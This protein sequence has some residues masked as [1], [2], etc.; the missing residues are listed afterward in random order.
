MGRTDGTMGTEEPTA[1][2]A[3]WL[4]LQWTQAVF[5]MA[6]TGGPGSRHGRP[7]EGRPSVPEAPASVDSVLP[8]WKPASVSD[9]RQCW[10][11]PM[12]ADTMPSGGLLAAVPG[13]PILLAKSGQIPQ[14]SSSP[15][16][17]T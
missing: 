9:F 17:V 7:S 5:Q 10:V 11:L 8:H 6:V 2:A 3:F 13:A 1:A 12:P 16:P 14:P 15:R 4:V